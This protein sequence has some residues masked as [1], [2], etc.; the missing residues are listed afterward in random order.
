V[1][2]EAEGSIAHGA[3]V[4]GR[5]RERVVGNAREAMRGQDRQV[6]EHVRDALLGTAEVE[7]DRERIVVG[8]AREA[9]QLRRTRVAGRRVARRPQREGH[10]GGGRPVAIVPPHVAAQPEG[11]RPAVRA[12]V[13]A[14]REV[15]LETQRAVVA[16][17]RGEQ[18]VALD[19]PGERVN[20]DQ[21]IDGLEVGAGR[22]Y[23]R[24]GRLYRPAAGQ[25][26]SEQQRASAHGEGN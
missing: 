26:Q 25:R 18:H 24:I 1:L 11:E 7:R 22:I 23:D 2:D 14:F 21:R 17:Q 10:V 5:E 16:N 4:E 6:G 15:W 9:R 8:D 12:P 19:L 13:P 20:G 3:V